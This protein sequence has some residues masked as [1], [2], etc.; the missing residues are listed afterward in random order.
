M[1]AQSTD[2]LF[3]ADRPAGPAGGEGRVGRA[4]PDTASHSGRDDGGL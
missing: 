2:S 3:T 1:V 4:G